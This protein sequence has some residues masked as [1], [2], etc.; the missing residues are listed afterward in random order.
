MLK[1]MDS[2]ELSE[3]VAFYKSLDKPPIREANQKQS[4]EEMM[5]IMKGIVAGQKKAVKWRRR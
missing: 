5:E 1:K 4:P 2:R 3:W